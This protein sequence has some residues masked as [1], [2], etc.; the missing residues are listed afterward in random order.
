MK[1]LADFM[2]HYGLRADSSAQELLGGVVKAFAGLPYENITKIIKRAVSGN[3]ER[4][5]RYPE[6]V[7]RDHIKWGTGGTCFSLTCALSHLLGN[8]GWKTEYI[9]ADRHYGQDTHCALLIWV[10]GVPHLLDPGYLMVNPIPLPSA[11]ERQIETGFNSIILA[12][13]RDPGRISLFTDRGGTKTHRL[14]YKISA[15]E[16]GDFL[17]AWD[18]SFG[19]DMMRYPLLTRTA[20]SGQVYVRGSRIQITG[21][22]AVERQEIRAGDLVSRISLEFRI[23]PAVVARAVSILR[24]RG[25]IAASRR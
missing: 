12:Q 21:S 14:T 22:N 7:I 25:E 23:H 9:L 10:E 11:K 13:E 6:E 1:A 19:W 15:V 3:P 2:A 20:S 17:K 24:G 16:I 4:S 5:R 8:L 18:A